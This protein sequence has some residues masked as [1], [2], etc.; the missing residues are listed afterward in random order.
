MD[1]CTHKLCQSCIVTNL[2]KNEKNKVCN[3]S[4]GIA[5][6]YQQNPQNVEKIKDKKQYE[7][8]P[9]NIQ[10]EAYQHYINLVNLE[11][12]KDEKSLFLTAGIENYSSKKFKLLYQ[13]SRDGFSASSF[14]EKCLN[15]GPNIW[16]ILSEYGK[17]FGAYTPIPWQ[18]FNSWYQD[19]QTFIF[20]LTNKSI[21]RQYQ[22]Y[23]HA[24][25]YN[26]LQLCQFGARGDI[27]IGSDSDQFIESVC[28]LGG[29]YSLPEGCDYQSDQANNYLA[30]SLHFKIIEIE[31][32]QLQ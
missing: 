24:I 2:E 9:Q 32:Y 5:Q 26:K 25:Y 22:N 18:N 3:L 31:V 1:E 29:T 14:H 10:S 27:F 17:V 11:L 19:E 21:H 30:G 16:F 6:K 7:R 4:Y 8:K 15:Q 20:S 23:R 13:A 28:Q 12:D